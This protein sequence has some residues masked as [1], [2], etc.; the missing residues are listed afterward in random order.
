M[1]SVKD[2]TDTMQFG[3]LGLPYAATCTFSKTSA[4][5]DANGTLSVQLTVDTGD[6]LGS[7]ENVAANAVF[8]SNGVVLAFLPMGL[9][10]G[11]ALVRGRRKALPILLL[12]FFAL[13]VTAGITGCSGLTTAGTPAGTYAF[14]VTA[15]GMGTGATQS[16][17]MT[18]TVK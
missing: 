4:K 18:L 8:R 2:F 15:S 10:A 16:Q 3:C 14:K 5:L 13:L 1:T 9:L 17:T 12:A 6:P 11:F 7:G